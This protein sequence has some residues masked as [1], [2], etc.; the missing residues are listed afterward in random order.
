[1]F[2]QTLGNLCT[3]LFKYELLF[4]VRNDYAVRYNMASHLHALHN[5]TVEICIFVIRILY[6]FTRVYLKYISIGRDFSKMKP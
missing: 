2:Y 6:V 1:M 5:I 3:H 4:V